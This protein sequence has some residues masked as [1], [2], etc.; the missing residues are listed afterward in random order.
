MASIL[1][2]FRIIFFYALYFLM[3]MV[4]VVTVL[5][6]WPVGG[7]MLFAIGLPIILVW[8]QESRRKRKTVA[9]NP[10]TGSTNAT[11]SEP[12]GQPSAY[13]KRIELERQKTR[14]ANTI[15]ASSSAPA[16]APPNQRHHRH[17]GTP[18]TAR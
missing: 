7:Q 12:A 6:G 8:W 16:N 18:P 5:Q 11:V 17:T 10:A 14:D 1:K 13:E 2:F 3:C 4:A 9:K 15:L